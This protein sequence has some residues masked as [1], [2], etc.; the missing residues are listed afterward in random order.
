MKEFE[1]D[2][3]ELRRECP[4]PTLL[5]KLDMGKYAVSS[6][7]SPFRDDV[8]PSWGIFQGKDQRWFWK[9]FGTDE[10]GDEVD[11]LATKF[12][13][14]SKNDF[15][16]ILEKWKE[17]ADSPAQ[18]EAI[19]N[20]ARSKEPT[21][22]NMVSF[23]PGTMDQI[24]RLSKSR[25][26]SMPA[27]EAADECG[28][29][30]FGWWRGHEVYG[31]RDKSEKVLM[32]RRL[33]GEMFPDNGSLTERK[34]HAI[35][36]SQISWPVGILEATGSDMILMVEGVPDFLAAFEIMAREQDDERSISP[37][38]MLSANVSIHPEAL[39]LFVGKHVRIV[40]HIDKAGITGAKQWQDQ[41]L[42]AG[43]KSIDFVDLSLFGK[44]VKDLNDCLP[45]YRQSPEDWRLL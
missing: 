30:V 5:Q 13:L 39:P 6:C 3:N 22:P 31:L 37:V 43:A 21:K 42:A 24:E 2:V 10:G 29:L 9:D 17:L 25:G 27:L 41:L 15:Q 34:S 14:D 40:P 20:P 32:L 1:V 4:L 12:E 38:A 11:F 44:K 33:D 26:I 19:V 28:F 8:N 36:G 7:R 16:T 45:L 23:V 18:P 35:R